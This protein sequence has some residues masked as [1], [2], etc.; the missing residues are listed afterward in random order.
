M[1]CCDDI[2]MHL[3]VVSTGENALICDMLYIG[4]F[5]FDFVMYCKDPKWR[6]AESSL[7]LAHSTSYLHVILL[8][9][10]GTLSK[11]SF[12]DQYLSNIP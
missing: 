3:K 10:P 7:G 11:L 2:K 4:Y 6:S 12:I 5:I 1:N 9:F 8:H